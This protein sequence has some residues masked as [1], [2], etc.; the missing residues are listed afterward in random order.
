[1]GLA[2][3]RQR[4]KAPVPL[5]SRRGRRLR[6]IPATL[7]RR[8]PHSVEPVRRIGAIL[9][10]LLLAGASPVAAQTLTA[11]NVGTDGTW[12]DPAFWT[13]ANFPDNGN[14]G[15]DYDVDLL[16]ANTTLLDVAA[17]IEDFTLFET[18][19]I[20]QAP[21]PG[22]LIVNGAM[23]FVT[24]TLDGPGSLRA[25]GGFAQGGNTRIRDGFGFENAGPATVSGFLTVG[26]GSELRNL[27]G[28]VLDFQGD[29]PFSAIGTSGTGRIV[30]EGTFQRSTSSTR[31]TLSGF[32][33]NLGLVQV[34]G[35]SELNLATAGNHTGRFLAEAGAELRFEGTGLGAQVLEAG[36]S[37]EG[38]G[39]VVVTAFPFDFQ[40]DWDVT[41]ATRF[42]NVLGVDFTGSITSVGAFRASNAQNV[43]FSTGLGD[44][45][46]FE[47]E[48]FTSRVEI[49][50][51]T[52]VLG[53]MT[54]NFGTLA[55]S[56]TTTVEGDLT[57]SGGTLDGHTLVST[58]DQTANIGLLNLVGASVVN[59]GRWLDPQVNGDATSSF[60]NTATGV[61]EVDS[62]DAS[63]DAFFINANNVNLKSGRFELL[64]GGN[65]V[66]TSVIQRSGTSVDLVLDGDHQFAPGSQVMGVSLV[67]F[68]G[69]MSTVQGSY[70]NQRTIVRSTAD[71]E[72]QTD[73]VSMDS[74]ENSGSTGFFSI[75]SPGSLAIATLVQGGNLFSE[76][77]LDVTDFDYRIGSRDTG[78]GLTTLSGTG[79]LDGLDL[80]AGRDMLLDGQAT[81]T[82]AR[83]AI[84][85]THRF[86]V[87]LSGSY[88]FGGSRNVVDGLGTLV[89]RG[90]IVVNEETEVFARYEQEDDGQLDVHDTATFSGGGSFGGNIRFF[91][92][93]LR[94]DDRPPGHPVGNDLYV[95]QQAMRSQGVGLWELLGLSLGPLA[96][97]FELTPGQNGTPEQ[98]SDGQDFLV[99][100]NGPVGDP[101]RMR[102]QAQQDGLYLL[103]ALRADG[104]NARM[105]FEGN[106]LV[107]PDVTFGTESLQGFDAGVWLEGQG[108]KLNIENFAGG[109][110]F[111]GNDG[112]EFEFGVSTFSLGSSFVGTRARFAELLRVAPFGTVDLGDAAA[113]VTQGIAM[114][115]FALIVVDEDSL[116]EI[117]GDSSF[118]EGTGID[119][120]G[121]KRLTNGSASFSGT[122]DDPVRLGSADVGG[123]VAAS[124]FWNFG[125]GSRTEAQIESVTDSSFQL[126]DGAVVALEVLAP[127]AQG[128][129]FAEVSVAAR[130]GS[131]LS[132]Q[133]GGRQAVLNYGGSAPA[134][135][136]LYDFRGAGFDADELW[137]EADV[138]PGAPAAQN[139][140]ALLAPAAPVAGT[141]V[142]S[143][144]MTF[145]TGSRFLLEIG[146]SEAGT[147]HDIWILMGE[148]EMED[149]VLD[150]TLFDGAE[151]ALLFDDVLTLIDTDAEIL[152][153]FLGIASGERFATS[154]GLG[155]FVVW[156]GAGSSF[157]AS[158]V[159]VTGFL[160]PEPGTAGLIA[161]GLALLGARRSRR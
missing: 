60:E 23:S 83:I 151:N 125:S 119:G 149:V 45:A 28:A 16:S 52:T 126:G 41:G 100:D 40:G 72:F 157:N 15:F 113:T 10:P 122:A 75:G 36:S 62:D 160:I 67:D 87:G 69:G 29:S 110:D 9:L 25:N 38:A 104:A 158:D 91:D 39:D 92:A 4:P 134:S 49:A 80:D 31:G 78:L 129:Y 42:E 153:S 32:F 109:L 154:D 54:W 124:W 22:S 143:G 50:G 102:F 56:G 139:P 1:M 35:G 118:E 142:T 107:L 135:A 101:T 58:S 47:L 77:D 145:R 14:G 140:Q 37:V 55:G 43:S 120:A 26:E 81:G 73:D 148:L 34:L 51:D 76:R 85:E 65:H 150:V 103:G 86:T 53:D 13:T 44:V 97:L 130:P 63:I 46:S 88:A 161:L 70:D 24:A 12:S 61:I 33:D 111:L 21:S 133:V 98:L 116:L 155:S 117:S 114:E 127:G 141:L 123:W 137:F 89:N 59:A 48:G 90:E 156:Y 19:L 20:T 5:G 128:R 95:L 30:N 64:A 68:T 93:T 132:I 74:L 11:T 112:G 79:N 6:R 131:D 159:V 2:P 108:Y 99:Q 57:G 144:D 138:A 27:V 96:A 106:N 84:G 71:V 94:F 8:A 82:D 152:G 7:G 136:G 146:G 105:E 17:T 121:Q 66:D 115:P 3:R 147:E 18:N